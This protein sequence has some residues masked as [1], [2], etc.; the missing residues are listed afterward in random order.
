MGK[1][2]SMIKFTG[3]VGDVVGRKGTKGG[4]IYSAYQPDIKNPQTPAQINQR[5]RFLTAT[6]L[7]HQLPNDALAGYAPIAASKRISRRTAY[8]SYLMS[9]KAAV[10]AIAEEGNE[11]KA[12]ISYEELVFSRGTDVY[13]ASTLDTE[14]PATIKTTVSGLQPKDIVHA[15]AIVPEAKTAF[16][17]VEQAGGASL[18]I[19]LNFPTSLQGENVHVYIYVQR[20]NDDNARATYLSFWDGSNFE[21]Q[22]TLKAIE[23]S[24]SYSATTYVGMARLS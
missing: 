12:T 11:Y 18:E 20:I 14:T 21:A 6:S 10:I 17:K 5:V 19:S 3:R 15:V 7:A 16:S 1:A 8:A 24:A 9:K 23:S 4:V 2:K 22:A 13:E